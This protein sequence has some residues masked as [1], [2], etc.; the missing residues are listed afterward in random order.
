MPFRAQ[1]YNLLL[2]MEAEVKLLGPKMCTALGYT[3]VFSEELYQFDLPAVKC[4]I[5]NS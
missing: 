4:E 2:G 3:V 5:S 1:R